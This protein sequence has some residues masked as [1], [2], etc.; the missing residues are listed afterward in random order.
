MKFLKKISYSEN[1]KET[2]YSYLDKRIF[3][4]KDNIRILFKSKFDMNSENSRKL[5]EY[6]LQSVSYTHL[7]VYKRQVKPRFLNIR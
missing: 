3:L 4:S 1:M 5:F 6:Y 2:L 7:D